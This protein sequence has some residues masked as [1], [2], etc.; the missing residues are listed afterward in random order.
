[1]R[2]ATSYIKLTLL[3]LLLLIILFSTTIKVTAQ[4]ANFGYKVGGNEINVWTPFYNLTLNLTKGIAIDKIVYKNG[5]KVLNLDSCFKSYPTLLLFATTNSTNDK[6]EVKLG[7]ETYYVTYPGSLSFYPW[8]VKSIKKFNDHMVLVL[9]PSTPALADIKPLLVE[10][11]MIIYYYNP[12]INLTLTF[13]NPSNNN[14]ILKGR[15]V[16]GT[17]Y[18]PEIG[19][20]LC[21]TRASG[22]TQGIMMMKDGNLSIKVVTLNN[23]SDII[24]NNKVKMVFLYAPRGSPSPIYIM[25]LKPINSSPE[26]VTGFSSVL[27]SP[28]GTKGK[29]KKLFLYSGILIYKPINLKPKENTSLNLNIIIAYTPDPASIFVYNLNDFYY[30]WNKEVFNYDLNQTFKFGEMSKNLTILKAINKNLNEKISNFE[31]KCDNLTKEIGEIEGQ[32]N[33]FKTN[34]KILSN[35]FAQISTELKRYSIKEV[36]LFILGLFIGILGGW[37]AYSTKI[38]F[39]GRK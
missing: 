17:I 37:I 15:E 3:S 13:I 6:Y 10:I 30:A 5:N 7:N 21:K 25:A 33:Y 11:K 18:G 12:L 31:K 39:E 24:R 27:L 35:N 38:K 2:R 23:L 29:P 9:V 19:I 4:T 26:G 34:N 16:N 22:W 14:I 1:M 20:A 32:L 28:L 36:G 8:K